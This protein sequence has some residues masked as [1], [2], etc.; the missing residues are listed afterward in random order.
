L[1]TGGGTGVLIPVPGQPGVV[2]VFG[3]NDPGQMEV[4]AYDQGVARPVKYSDDLRWQGRSLRGVGGPNGRVYLSNGA[5]LRELEL[6]AD[7]LHLARNLDA[8]DRH[9]DYRMAVANGLLIQGFNEVLDL[10]SL[11][12]LPLGNF[13]RPSLGGVGYQQFFVNPL[14]QILRGFDL[15]SR[16]LKWQLTLPIANGLVASGGPAGVLITGYGGW[17]PTPPNPGTDLQVTAT[18]EAP[19]L[20]VGQEFT[21]QLQLRQEGVWQ[22]PNLKLFADLPPGLE[23]VSPVSSGPAGQLPLPD[24]TDAETLSVVLRANQPGIRPVT[25]RLTSDAQDPTPGDAQ[26]TVEVVVPEE[27]VLLL[28][29]LVTADNG[30]PLV[31]RLSTRAPR[32]LTVRLQA[33]LIDA[34][35]NDLTALTFDVQFPTGSRETEVRWVNP[36]NRLEPDERFRI[37][38]LPGD[39]TGSST[40]AVVTIANDDRASFQVRSVSQFEGHTNGTPTVLSIL[41]NEAQSLPVELGFRTLSGTA[42]DGEDFQPVAGRLFFAPGQ[43]TNLISIPIVGDRRLEQNEIFSVD[44]P[45]SFGLL[46]PAGLPT[47]T[48]R[49]DDAPASPLAVLGHDQDGRLVISFPSEL[50]AN[51][52]LQSGTN[53]TEGVWQTEPGTLPG[54]GGVLTV[55]PLDRPDSL[56]FYRLQAN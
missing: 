29:D 23:L 54:T 39:V 17:F 36:D 55:R 50:G 44:F 21:V 45:D 31:L 30:L 7:G 3:L 40:S 16:R 33:E 15:P 42:V 26:A 8:F 41:L 13:T 48:L 1:A 27:P 22:A 20:G 4:I 5:Q 10:E 25:F 46:L 49:N 6:R 32:S 18:L 34:Q 51:Y 38:L 14:G 47:V 11:T 43:R 2:V 53:L 12:L 56:R 52:A 35:A 24:F 9:I 28:S 19:P 37:V